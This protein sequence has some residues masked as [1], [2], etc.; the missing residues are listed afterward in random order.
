MATSVFAGLPG[1]RT[2]IIAMAVPAAF[3]L[4]AIG[5]A[6]EAA[7]HIQQYISV[8]HGVRWVGV[9]FL[10]NA[11]ASLVTIAGLAM[12]QT[13]ALAAL[14]G[15]VISTFALAALVVSYGHGLFGWQEGGLRTPVALAVVAEVIAVIALATALAPPAMF[16]RNAA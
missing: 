11:V 16:R 2:G 5:L 13:R 12:P 6:G 10:A 7:V 15:I 14:A 4:G 3:A 1:R 9:L 8:L